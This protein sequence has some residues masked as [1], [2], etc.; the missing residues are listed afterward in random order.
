[1][2]FIFQNKAVTVRA[3]FPYRSPVPEF[4]L[5]FNRDDVIRNVQKHSGGWWRGDIG[6]EHQKWFPRAFVEEMEVLESPF[7]ALQAGAVERRVEV[8]KNRSPSQS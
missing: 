4:E 7:G 8:T 1:V 6:T 3:V 2:H 5:T